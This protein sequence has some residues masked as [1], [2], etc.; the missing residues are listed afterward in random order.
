M[1][2][3]EEEKCLYTKEELWAR[4]VEFTGGRAAERNRIWFGDN[5][6]IQ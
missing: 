2:I 5:R 3:P 6:S 4:L 1:N